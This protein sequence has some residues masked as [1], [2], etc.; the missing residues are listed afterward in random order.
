MYSIVPDIPKNELMTIPV[1][2]SVIIVLIKNIKNNFLLI[3]KDNNL[4]F[5]ANPGDI[6]SIKSVFMRAIDTE[7]EML[8]QFTKNC[9]KLNQNVF[10]KDIILD[11][12]LE[13]TTT[14]R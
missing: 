11:R 1:I 5:V 7:K 9:D 12:L 3:V 10:N 2:A 4:G 14:R 8:E 6:K 13:L